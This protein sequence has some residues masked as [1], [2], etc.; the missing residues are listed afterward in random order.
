VIRLLGM[1]RRVAIQAADI[2]AGMRRRGKVPLLAFL[3][4][5]AQATRVNVRCSHSFKAGDLGD[6]AA[7]LYVGGPGAM[8]R[9]TALSVFEGCLEVRSRFEVLLVK[10]FVASLAHIG[11]DEVG[12]VVIGWCRVLVLTA[13]TNRL[14]EQQ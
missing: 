5:T 11:S 12:C 10:I 7:A 4:M 2:V 6:V 3:R 9:L 13:S 8:T 14:C 1:V